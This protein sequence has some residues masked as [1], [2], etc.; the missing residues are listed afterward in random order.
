MN[1]SFQDSPPLSAQPILDAMK[2]YDPYTYYH[3]IN[4]HDP[5]AYY[6]IRQFAIDYFY[7]LQT[8]RLNNTKEPK[9]ENHAEQ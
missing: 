2:M 6:Y 3:I 7:A 4:T 9:H 5:K 1:I 8:G